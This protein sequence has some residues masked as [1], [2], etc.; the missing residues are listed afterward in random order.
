MDK[1][2]LVTKIIGFVQ[3]IIE[4]RAEGSGDITVTKDS[5]LVGKDAI[6]DSHSLVELML[7]IEEYA[8]DTLDVE[9]AWQS[10]ATLSA[11]RSIFRSPETLADHLLTLVSEDA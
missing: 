9:F 6:I 1:Q 10:D 3:E 5:V 7:E 8:E 11:A 4:D 2:V